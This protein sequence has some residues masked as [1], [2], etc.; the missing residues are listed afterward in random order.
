MASGVIALLPQ[1]V[2]G[3]HA[4]VR[5]Y[6]TNTIAAPTR[7]MTAAVIKDDAMRRGEDGNGG[8]PSAAYTEAR[9]ERW[10]CAA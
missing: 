8:K 7:Q 3:A 1:V 4:R 9:V 2:P 5:R 6:L 10:D